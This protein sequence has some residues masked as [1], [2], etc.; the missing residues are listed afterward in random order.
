VTT[1]GA[2][3]TPAPTGGDPPDAEEIL[4]TAAAGPA[5]VRGGAWR[6]GG[7]VLGSLFS[8]LAAALLYRHL[9]KTDTGVYGLVIA[10][11]GIIGG[12]SDLGLTQLGIR[13]LSVT[14]RAERANL[15]R[16]LLGLRV[17]LTLIGTAAM[18]V[19]ARFAY[20][21]TVFIG[22]A[23]AGAGLLLQSTQDNLGSILQV[24]LR[25]RWVAA[26]DVLRQAA[27]AAFFVLLVLLGAHLLVFVSVNVWVGIIV[28]A[29]AGLLVRRQR[30]LLPRFDVAS[31]RRLL[32]L[33]LPY[34]AA[35]IAATLYGR[36]ALVL[37]GLISSP[38]QL[39]YFTVS[40]RV[41]DVL[42][43]VPGLLVGTALP[44]FAR[45]ARDDHARFEFGIT[46][47][48]EVA[49]IAGAGTAVALGIGAP[50]VVSILGG[51]TFRPAAGVLALQGIGFGAAYVSILWG[52]GLISQ[53][54]YRELVILNAC[55]VIA[56][57][58]VVALLVSADG[59]RGA[60]I[61]TSAVEI[62]MALVSGVL[63]CHRGAQRVRLRAGVL[64]KVALASAV[65]ITPVFWT[66]APDIVRL[67]IAG[68]LYAAVILLTRALPREVDALLPSWWPW[69]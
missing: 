44:I 68:A 17:V 39:S 57:A 27:T 45:A 33:V 42:A 51:G 32:R 4:S 15:A 26:L 52:T 64:A 9:G 36:E 53:G 49:L 6:I 3:D 55:G 47:V 24:N 10:L 20:S 50:L 61:G 21:S 18:L 28:V 48:F 31:S 1:S 62:A 5:A 46:R 14:P 54:R 13:E 25:F 23:I 67:I 65:A 8:V 63:V 29:A 43:T 2:A 16:D 19:F 11:V 58:A 38:H 7:F 40:S 41:I 35:M 30:S 69:R 66:A 37:V 12:V 59:A 22:V 34:S 56:L 60:A